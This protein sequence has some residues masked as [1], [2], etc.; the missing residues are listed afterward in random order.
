MTNLAKLL[1]H[2]A[3]WR[4]DTLARVRSGSISTG[5]DRLDRELPGGGWPTGALTEILLERQGIG[6]LSLLLPAL[7][8][9]AATGRWQTWIA[10]PHTPYA[11]RLAATG[12]DLRRLIIVHPSAPA[13]VQAGVQ[14]G[15]QPGTRPHAQSRS[16]SRAESGGRRVRPAGDDAV[17]HNTLW[18]IEQ[19]LRANLCGAVLA[20]LPLTTANQRR[21]RR[22]DTTARVHYTALRRLQLAAETGETLVVLFRPAQAAGEPSPA[23]LRLSLGPVSNGRLAVHILKRRGIAAEAPVLIDLKR[24]HAVDRHYAPAP[25]A[26]SL[27]AQ[28]VGS[29]VLN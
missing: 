21:A 1:E 3:L 25:A 29:N 12:I 8:Q 24:P 14:P 23:A 20:W 5:F 15:A 10:P 17:L 19:T 2:P 16:P 22:A 4:G 6:E 18:S 9:L 26:G 28:R 13:A 11:P 27:P 7:A